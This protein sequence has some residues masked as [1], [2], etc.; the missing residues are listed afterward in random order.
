MRFLF[1][2]ILWLAAGAALA[3]TP[4]N[5]SAASAQTTAAQTPP[6]SIWVPE[7]DGYRHLQSGLVCPASLLGYR[8]TETS[9]FDDYGLDV[10]CNYA[11][12]GRGVTLYLT[13]R[14]GS[15]IDAAMAEA[16][17]ELLQFGADKHPQTLGNKTST[18]NGLNWMVALYGE[19]GGAHSGI[20]IADLDGWTLEFRATYPAADEEATI[21]DLA[22]FAD[23][24]KASAGPT[25]DA[26]SKS[27]T[28]QRRGT[29][30]TDQ[31]ANEGAA[32]MTSI[33]GGAA[34]AAAADPKNK[35]DVKEEPLFWCPEAPL[36]SG[37]HGMLFWRAVKADGSD[38]RSDKIS[39]MT[40]D[41][42]PVLMLSGDSLAGLVEAA[43]D[44]SG[45]DGAAALERDARHPR[46][47]ADLRLFQRSA[48]ARPCGRTVR[49]DPLGQGDG[50]RRLQRQRQK[51]QHHRA[52]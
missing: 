7:K 36:Q 24:A 5:A 50:A 4:P 20:W 14:A 16:K 37:A 47:G 6:L 39:L 51:H 32:M 41:E 25:L 42:P 21:A 43:N 27:Q 34:L 8:R 31:K 49:P 44:K 29:L 35:D 17:R 2:L 1:G 19:D 45:K 28:P 33:L 46:S 23:A 52:R 26:C 12:H 3:D 9:F 38:G 11:G 10:G 48:L 40:R 13:R 30:I 18:A 22:A 15:G